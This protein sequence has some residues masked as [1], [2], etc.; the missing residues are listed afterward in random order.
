[1]IIFRVVL[2]AIL[3][4]SIG[5]VPTNANPSFSKVVVF[6]DSNVDSG[7][8]QENS[9][10]NLSGGIF[11]G[12]P[13]VGG[14]N[15]NGPVVVEYV[16]DILGVPLLDYGVSG[17]RTG[18]TNLVYDFVPIAAI[19]FTGVLSQIDMFKETLHNNKADSQ[20]LYIYW[21]GSNDLFGATVDDVPE[22]VNTALDNIETALKTL[23]DLGARY[24]L[25]ATRT[26]RPEYYSENNVN[27]MVLN[28]RVRTL[29]QDLNEELKANIKIFEAFDL[30]TDMTYNAAAYGFVETTDLCISIPDCVD[31]P[32]ISDTYITWDAAHKTTRTHEVMA[33]ELV[34]QAENM[35]KGK[36]LGVHS[37]K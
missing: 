9:L 30:I 22:R 10:Y 17:A 16:A 13:N 26:I 6:G 35:R 29:V 31:N 12:P 36:G 28:G 20:A 14:R 21:A 34:I 2:I 19:Q 8:A 3:I 1:M 27:G 5:S 25:V 33:Y 37:I 15:C 24:I 7:E 32:I 18:L 23:T 4:L 11:N